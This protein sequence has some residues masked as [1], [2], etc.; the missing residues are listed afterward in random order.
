[1]SK[2]NS[3]LSADLAAAIAAYDP[4]TDP[5]NSA[6]AAAVLDAVNG[7]AVGG[8]AITRTA[9]DAASIIAQQNTFFQQAIAWYGGTATGGPNNDGRYNLTDV[10]GNTYLVPSPA[11]LAAELKAIEI[12]DEGPF[13]GRAA[14]DGEDEGFTYLSTDGEDGGGGPAV[15]YR[16][17]AGAGVWSDPVPFE[18]PQ[19]VTGDPGAE[20]SLQVTATHIQWRLGA[21]AWADL[22]ALSALLGPQGDPGEEVSLQVTATHIQWRVGAG[23]WAD[24]IAL[25]ALVGPQ[26]LKGDTGS[27]A[28]DFEGPWNSGTAYVGGKI[29]T[30]DGETWYA[31]AGS[32][33]ITPGTDASKWSKLAARGADGAG[34]G[35]V[36]SVA[37]NGSNGIVVTGGPIT[38]SGTLALSINAAALKAHLGYGVADVSGLQAAL[39][40]K[41]GRRFAKTLRARQNIHGGGTISYASG[42]LKWS[43]RFITQVGK[44]TD[45][46]AAGFFLVE[47]PP[48]GTTITGAGG[49]SDSTVDADGI[50]MPSFGVLYYV[51]PE[52]VGSSQ[53]GNFRIVDFNSV[54][55]VPDNWL[56]IA[57]QNPDAS[58]PQVF[59]P[60]GIWLLAGDS[61]DMAA[62]MATGSGGG[63]L[64]VAAI[65]T[66]AFRPN[67]SEIT[68]IDTTAAGVTLTDLPDT[69]TYG[70]RSVLVP[71]AESWSVSN[72]VTLPASEATPINGAAVDLIVTEPSIIDMRYVGSNFGWEVTVTP[73][74]AADDYRRP[75]VATP[76]IT[77]PADAATGQPEAPT[78]T[79]S[80]FAMLF[81][82]DTHAASDWQVAS[83]AGFSTVVAESLDEAANKTSWTM[84]PGDLQ[85]STEYY[86]RVRHAAATAGDS[87]WS[88]PVSFTTAASFVDPDIAAIWAA[89]SITD[90]TRRALVDALVTG[91][92]SDGLWSKLDVLYLLAAGATTAAL[93]NW[94]APGTYDL[95]PVNNPTFM[96]NGG[97]QGNASSSW[98]DTGF[99]PATNGV[100]YTQNAHSIGVRVEQLV[101]QNSR[102]HMGATDESGNDA[103]LLEDMATAERHYFVSNGVQVFV[104]P[105]RLTGLLA[106]TRVN[107]NVL[108]IYRRGSLLA[109]ASFEGPGSVSANLAIL[110]NGTSG[111]AIDFSDARVSAAFCGG[112]LTATD[113]ANLN[114]RINTYMAGL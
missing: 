13:S 95:T 41:A 6:L 69:T 11:K 18:G 103:L 58:T 78:F 12:G 80:A 19:G 97:Y 99:N 42:R 114:T 82:S 90:P 57:S 51:L 67:V 91:L 101:N 45:F 77:S 17:R 74:D 2:T 38:A 102:A 34:A 10:A 15:L 29:V 81:G 64:T 1:M 46:A 44:T 7:W 100:Q 107:A 33:N 105:P 31:E 70:A 75:T 63:G 37:A 66:S 5:D 65:K 76:A 35:S 56:Q 9:A 87:A 79:S 61:V 93:V 53:S 25:S 86:A 32:T 84:A 50:L 55:D 24:L 4:A 72:P 73:L 14:Y 3:E 113:H 71:H 110:A 39:D 21:G 59:L 49:A 83:D 48:V 20:V 104:S 108:E 52:T 96:A 88:D 43:E 40:N 8:A 98:L 23:A 106:G 60:N 68:P 47:M 85:V 54:F 30:H 109:S 111:G 92:K 62:S 36:T 89:G 26:G 28:N 94:K 22:I 16:K 27:F 112:L